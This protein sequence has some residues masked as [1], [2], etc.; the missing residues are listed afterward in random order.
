MDKRAGRWKG[1]LGLGILGALAIGA[2][3]LAACRPKETELA[4]ETLV[5]D[6]LGYF[7][8]TYESMDLM[9]ATSVAEAQQIADAL[10]PEDPGKRF[11]Q[12]MDV[13]YGEY[14]VVVA[15]LGAKPHGGFV[16][17]IEKIAQ[18]GRNVDVAIS[19]VEPSGGDAIFV[20]PI[21]AVKVRRADLSVKGNLTFQLWKGGEVVLTRAHF[22]R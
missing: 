22:V 21:H 3:G 14:F 18:T 20:H 19:T 4:F 5:Q 13:N 1:L 11:E 15:Y 9:I 8:A 16:V 2:A 12:I 6:D 10:S 7:G 17:T